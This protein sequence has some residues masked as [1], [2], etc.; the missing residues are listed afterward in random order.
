MTSSPPI[1]NW[2]CGRCVMVECR[3]GPASIEAITLIR[4]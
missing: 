1:R 3:E 2:H 4:E